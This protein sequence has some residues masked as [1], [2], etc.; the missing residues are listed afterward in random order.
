MNVKR[1]E[2]K[3]WTTGA[4]VC[5]A[6]P[7]RHPASRQPSPKPLSCSSLST[8]QAGP[9]GSY[10]CLYS[11]IQLTSSRIRNPPLNVNITKPVSQDP[12]TMANLL[13]LSILVLCISYA[14]AQ[15][16]TDLAARYS[17]TQTLALPFPTTTLSSSQAQTFLKSDWGLARGS[18]QQGG[19]DLAFVSDPFASGSSSSSAAGGQNGSS[20]GSVLQVTYPQG[21]F[22]HE[23]GG[24]QFINL[25]N[26]SS[27]GSSLSSSKA[28]S[29]SFNSMLLTYDLAFDS[30][31]DFVRGGKLPGLR[32]GNGTTGCSGGEASDGANCFTARLM[33]RE[34]GAGEGML[35]YNCLKC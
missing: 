23:T 28:S 25:F 7:D 35:H 33:W 4:Y 18:L 8:A 31:F 34:N 30:D 26:A 21:S 32:G 15:S 11:Q 24:A 16:A 1:K 22:S 29:E 6:L 19:D 20:S 3:K 2:D 12:F 13:P 5:Y 27:S 14:Q 9:F 10:T 17:L